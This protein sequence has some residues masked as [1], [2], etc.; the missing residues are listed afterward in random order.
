MCCRHTQY[1]VGECVDGQHGGVVYLCQ[2]TGA[3]ASVFERFTDSFTQ[4]SGGSS[5]KCDGCD[6]RRIVASFEHQAGE[7]LRQL[8]RLAGA[9]PGSNQ[10]N[11]KRDH[12]R[13][14]KNCLGS[15]VGAIRWRCGQASATSQNR[16]GEL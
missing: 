12:R 10:F 14:P 8:V 5:G 4:F 15:C 3:G 13:T 1:P 7:S 2:H 6:A 11:I 16:H 9:G